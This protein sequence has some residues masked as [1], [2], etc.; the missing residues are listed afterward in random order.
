MI[1]AIGSDHAGFSLKGGLIHHVESL[2]HKVMDCG[3]IDAAPSDYPDIAKAVASAVVSGRADRGILICGS[4]VGAA[5]AATKVPGILAGVC[6]DSYSA[7]QAVEHDNLNI[8]CLG[9]RVIGPSLAEEVV[10]AYLGAEFS[11]EERHVRRLQKIKEIERESA[12]IFAD[13][14]SEVLPR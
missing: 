14:P 2:G 3:G 6:H 8:L 1:I 11:G 13:A 12:G 5:I 10:R 7:R 9:S 4:G